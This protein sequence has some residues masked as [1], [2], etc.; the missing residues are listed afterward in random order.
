MLYSNSRLFKYKKYRKKSQNF[1]FITFGGGGRWSHKVKRGLQ[2]G[3]RGHVLNETTS[4]PRS[5]GTMSRVLE[6]YG[7]KEQGVVP[8]GR[9]PQSAMKYGNRGISP[10]AVL[11]RH[12]HPLTT[13][14]RERERKRWLVP[15]A[16]EPKTQEW[17]EHNGSISPSPQLILFNV[18]LLKRNK[19]SLVGPYHGRELVTMLLRERLRVK[20]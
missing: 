19:S 11:C 18:L 15:T 1:K 16:V 8:K 9:S 6:S 14:E 3:K 4:R 10:E 12:P 13:T 2:D 7:G 20:S 5:L 17:V